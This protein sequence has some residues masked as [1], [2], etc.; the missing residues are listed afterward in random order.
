MAK[1]SEVSLDE[2]IYKTKYESFPTKEAKNK[3]HCYFQDEMFLTK[4]AYLDGVK[5]GYFTGLEE[6]FE[7]EEY[8]PEFTINRIRDLIEE[9]DYEVH[10]DFNEEVWSYLKDMPEVEAFIKA[11]NKAFQSQITY[12]A[13]KKRIENDSLMTN[14][15]AGG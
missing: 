11:V 8:V 5:E 10:E 12:H 7:T 6:L 15:T 3:T 4:K 13:T 14:E 9:N 1:L 2:Y